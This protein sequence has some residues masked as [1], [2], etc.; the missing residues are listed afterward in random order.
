M[1]WDEFS[2]QPL[3]FFSFLKLSRKLNKTKHTVIH[4]V[5]VCVC[6]FVQDNEFGIM[7]ARLSEIF[8]Q[9]FHVVFKIQ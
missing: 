3:F 4:I 6:V 9:K 1:L 8:E 7:G 2:Y 5:C